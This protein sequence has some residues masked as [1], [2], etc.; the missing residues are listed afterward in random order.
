MAPS[1][2]AK[3]KAAAGITADKV[4]TAATE[5][6]ARSGLD[7]WSVRD[8]AAALTVYPTVIYHHVGDREAV[9]HAVVER[10]VA[11]MPCPPADLPWREW[12]TEFLWEGREV[13][14]RYPGV[15]RRLCL[16]GPTVPSALRIIDRG[17][18]VLQRAGFGDQAVAVY[19][20][21][22]GTAFLH[23]PLED[24]RSERVDERLAARD[25]FLAHGRGDDAP[26]LATVA[27]QLGGGGRSPEELTR[28]DELHYRSILE[29][30]LDGAAA[31]LAHLRA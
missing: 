4:T 14:R 28:T 18:V 29:L 30:S 15:A 13:L 16:A 21:L 17:V 9:L 20:F 8:L 5:L 2:P 26:G 10:V 19:T 31:R 3:S 12:F 1:T 22:V 6:T 24:E 25:V 23:V 27:A 11:H 7:G